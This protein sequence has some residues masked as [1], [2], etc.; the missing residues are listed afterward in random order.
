M[1]KNTSH[2]DKNYQYYALNTSHFDKNYEY[3]VKTKTS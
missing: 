3:Y 2:C 1:L